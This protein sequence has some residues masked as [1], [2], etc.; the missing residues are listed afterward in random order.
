MIRRARYFLAAAGTAAILAGG[1]A[2]AGARPAFAG[3]LPSCAGGVNCTNSNGDSMRRDGRLLRCRRQPHPLQVRVD[4]DRGH[5]AAGE[6][7]RGAPPEQGDC[8]STG[9]TLCDPN[10]GQVAQLS[11]YAV[12]PGAYRVLYVV[13]HFLTSTSEP[14]IQNGNVFFK[15]ITSVGKSC[16]SPASARTT[17]SSSKSPTP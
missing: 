16:S 12:A 15:S 6:A 3:T 8:G 9:V 11:L 4:R 7:E 17:R 13:G 2:L 1:M 10:T 14:C 5:P